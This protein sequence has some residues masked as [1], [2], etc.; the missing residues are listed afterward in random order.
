[1]NTRM[2]QKNESVNYVFLNIIVN[3]DIYRYTFVFFHTVGYMLVLFM[4]IYEIE[5]SW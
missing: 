4:S 5:S 2:K 1:M 3:K